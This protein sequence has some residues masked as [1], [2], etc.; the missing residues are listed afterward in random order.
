MVKIPNI[1]CNY[2]KLAEVHRYIGM[3]AFFCCV[4]FECMGKLHALNNPYMV[5]LKIC[6]SVKDLLQCQSVSFY[7][8][9]LFVSAVQLYSVLKIIKTK[10]KLEILL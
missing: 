9:N 7:L 8:D 2:Y 4:L 3:I 5:H 6:C 10:K 1:L